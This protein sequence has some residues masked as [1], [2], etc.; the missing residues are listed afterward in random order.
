MEKYCQYFL[1]DIFLRMGRWL[2]SKVTHPLN[3]PPCGVWWQG[4]GEKERGD[5]NPSPVSLY[6]REKLRSFPL[7]KRGNKGGF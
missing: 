7:W 2:F 6:E 5:V 4:G 1:G 3:P